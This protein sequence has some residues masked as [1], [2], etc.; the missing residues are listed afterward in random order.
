MKA[1]FLKQWYV[2]RRKYYAIFGD[3]AVGTILMIYCS[4]KGSYPFKLMTLLFTAFSTIFLISLLCYYYFFEERKSLSI[5]K[6]IQ[7]FGVKKIIISS[8]ITE[9]V[10]S[11]PISIYFSLLAFFIDKHFSINQINLIVLFQMF[12]TSIIVSA[13]VAW[14]TSMVLTLTD[15]QFAVMLVTSIPIFFIFALSYYMYF[16]LLIL[17]ISLI[18]TGIITKKAGKLF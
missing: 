4:T 18:L 16:I 13:V 3:L 1:L 17:I 15:S 12:L 10:I 7:F 14:L 6:S 8:V 11:L 5:E 2:I 9:F